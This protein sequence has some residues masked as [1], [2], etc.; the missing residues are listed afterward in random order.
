M[1]TQAAAEYPEGDPVVKISANTQKMLRWFVDG[2][3]ENDW[4]KADKWADLV[5]LGYGRGAPR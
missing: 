5:F 3:I 2:V 4:E 1:S